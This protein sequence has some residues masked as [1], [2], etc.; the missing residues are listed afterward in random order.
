MSHVPDRMWLDA[1]DVV[2][3][4]LDDAFAGKAISVPSR[5][6]KALV[7]AARALPRPVLRAVMA[8]RGM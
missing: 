1:K 2:R 3:E 8:R 6:Y 4:G 7:G 5:R